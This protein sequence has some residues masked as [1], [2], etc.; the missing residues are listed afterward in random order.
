[1][2]PCYSKGNLCM[3]ASSSGSCL[4][5]ACINQGVI[6]NERVLLEENIFLARENEMSIDWNKI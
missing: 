1:M 3:Y 6:E 5:S 4:C 2:K